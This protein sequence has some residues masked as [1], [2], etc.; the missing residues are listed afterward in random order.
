MILSKR[1]CKDTQKRQNTPTDMEKK[2]EENREK[3]PY[4][5]PLSFFLTSEG[6]IATSG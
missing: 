2:Q 1:H 6:R 3:P 5:P 4:S